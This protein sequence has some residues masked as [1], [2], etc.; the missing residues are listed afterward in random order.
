MANQEI[1]CDELVTDHAGS[2]LEIRRQLSISRA[3]LIAV[4]MIRSQGGRVMVQI[5]IRDA[6]EDDD[7]LQL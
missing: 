7:E 1:V 2:Y 4:Q 5:C 6:S 3:Y